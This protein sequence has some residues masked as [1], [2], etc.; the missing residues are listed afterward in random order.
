M[1]KRIKGSSHFFLACKPRRTNTNALG[2]PVNWLIEAN[3]NHTSSFMFLLGIIFYSFQTQEHFMCIKVF[4]PKS[5][6][7][8]FFQLY[9]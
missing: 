5:F 9:L 4:S 1:E 6:L 2:D 3:E 8:I 7:V